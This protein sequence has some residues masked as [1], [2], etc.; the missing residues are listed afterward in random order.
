MRRRPHDR[1]NGWTPTQRSTHSQMSYTFKYQRSVLFDKLKETVVY[2]LSLSVNRRFIYISH[3]HASHTK[4]TYTYERVRLI[5]CVY[6]RLLC[7]H[8]S[9]RARTHRKWIS[10]YSKVYIRD[11]QSIIVLCSIE[12]VLFFSCTHTLT[13][14]ARPI[15]CKKFQQRDRTSES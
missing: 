4:S 13:S 15:A 8:L 1:R 14:D 7:G 9:K 5:N 12:K 11:R 2:T 3:T 10:V 6:M